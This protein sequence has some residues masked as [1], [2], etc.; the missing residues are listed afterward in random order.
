MKIFQGNVLETIDK[1][2][3]NSIQSIIT[4]PPYFCLRDYEHPQQIG[5]ESQVDDYLNKLIQIWNIGKNKLKDNGLLFI[6][7]DD[8]YYYQREAEIKKWGINGN[9]TVRPA[10]KKHEKYIESSLFAVPQKLVI[11]M[12]ESGWIFRQQIIWQKPNCMPE[13]TEKKF[14]KDYEVIFM[15]SKSKFHKFNFLQEDMVT[16]DLSRPKGSKGMIPQAG[17]RNDEKSIKA[18]YKRHMR[19]VWSIP[20]VSTK[21]E[22]HYATFPKELARRLILCSTDENDTVLDPFCGSGTTL[23]V[24]K[25][26]NRQGI[27]IEIN[28]GYVKLAEKNI[29]DLFTKVE[30]I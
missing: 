12:L 11:K 8:T 7:I 26:L 13:S 28:E 15:F 4:S 3:D 5:I 27:G 17:R 22:N 29:N 2:E 25:Q 10:I 21:N 19:S 6:N 9:F 16:K 18:E 23:K 20:T 1:I 24:A 14:T 30:V